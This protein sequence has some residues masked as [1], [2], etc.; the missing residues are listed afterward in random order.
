MGGH[1]T[2]CGCPTDKISVRANGAYVPCSLLAHMELGRINRDSLEDI[3]RESEA[4]NQLRSRHTIPLTDFEFCAG[5]DYIPYCTGNC[6]AL[7]YSLTG[8]VDHPSPDAC[9]RRFLNAGGKL[10]A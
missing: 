10:P 7:A 6:P 9:L 4:M 1:L 2:A 5:C 8:K 3:W